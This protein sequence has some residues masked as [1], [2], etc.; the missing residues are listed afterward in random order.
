MPS[1][2]ACEIIVNKGFPLEVA[3]IALQLG[4]ND[5]QRAIEMLGGTLRLLR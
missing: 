3:T 5:V 1:S 2:E 4:N